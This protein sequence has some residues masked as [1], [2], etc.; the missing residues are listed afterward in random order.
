MKE[1]HCCIP[2]PPRSM[3]G[4]A[5]TRPDIRPREIEDEVHVEEREHV[6]VLAP[7]LA[8]RRLPAERRRNAQK[9]IPASPAG[10]TKPCILEHV[11]SLKVVIV[12]V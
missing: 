2:P 9:W 11:P 3:S 4:M 12:G 6:A 1:T 7:H 5:K 8:V 10:L